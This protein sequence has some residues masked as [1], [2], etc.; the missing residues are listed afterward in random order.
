MSYAEGNAV[1][2][3]QKMSYAEGIFYAEGGRRHSPAYAE[4]NSYADG[5]DVGGSE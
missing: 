2:V 4:G 5:R 3:A 1:G